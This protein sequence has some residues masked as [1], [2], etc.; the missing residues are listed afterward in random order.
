M[1]E[2]PSA[3]RVL[4]R[5]A[6][7]ELVRQLLDAAPVGSQTELGDLLAAEGVHVTQGTI[8][9]DL[10]ELRAVRRRDADG[11][12]RYVVPDDEDP[13]G[14]PGQVARLVRLCGEVLLDAQASGNLVVARTP[15]GAAQYFASAIDKAGLPGVLGTIAGDDTVLLIALDPS[16]G[17]DVAEI[18]M[19]H[20][21]GRRAAPERTP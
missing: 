3:D 17:S 14:E 4:S 1:T 7:R 20:A 12:L 11:A 10:L 8:S 5:A 21:A 18:L 9:K 16:G 6:R 15:P 19:T 2:K 13:A